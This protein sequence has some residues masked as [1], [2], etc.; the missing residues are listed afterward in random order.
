MFTGIKWIACFLDIR[1]MLLHGF[2]F[3]GVLC[4]GSPHCQ[5]MDQSTDGAARGVHAV[6]AVRRAGA[7][8]RCMHRLGDAACVTGKTAAVLYGQLFGGDCAYVDV[9]TWTKDRRCKALPLHVA[10]QCILKCCSQ[11]G[12]CFLSTSHP[13]EGVTTVEPKSSQELNV[14]TLVQSL[15]F[16][17]S[18]VQQYMAVRRIDCECS[19]AVH[20]RQGSRNKTPMAGHRC[21]A[22]LTVGCVAFQYI[23]SGLAGCRSVASC[24]G[25]GCGRVRPS[26]PFG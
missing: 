11:D 6:P 5:T 19:S 16:F 20:V 4:R 22:S 24:Q 15:L 3:L 17:S 8:T 14:L 10:G 13:L 1:K 23:V 7:H 12:W 25:Y 26:T 9:C 21:G 2:D 18:T